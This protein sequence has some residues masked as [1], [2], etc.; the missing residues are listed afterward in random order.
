[1]EYNGGS[2]ARVWARIWMVFWVMFSVVVGIGWDRSFGYVGQ[3]GVY[4]G[5]E[6]MSIL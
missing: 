5:D 1:M 6:G 2:G 3:E 4:V